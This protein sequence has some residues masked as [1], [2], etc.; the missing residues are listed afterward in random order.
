[1]N[2]PETFKRLCDLVGRQKHLKCPKIRSHNPAERWADVN[3]DGGTAAGESSVES[4]SGSGEWIKH[5]AAFHA[6][7]I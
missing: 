6:P 2:G 3:T 1:M 4:R 7:D 5:I